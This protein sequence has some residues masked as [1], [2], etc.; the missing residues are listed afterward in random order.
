MTA[1]DSKYI[2]AELMKAVKYDSLSQ[3]SHT[4]YDVG[5]EYRRNM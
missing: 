1:R 4:L 2:F 3:I 5:G